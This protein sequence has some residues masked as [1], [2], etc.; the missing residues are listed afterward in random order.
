MFE[1]GK[2]P[3]PSVGPSREC[4]LGI[5]RGGRAASSALRRAKDGTD[6][7]RGHTHITRRPRRPVLPRLAS[8][9]L[10][11][12]PGEERVCRTLRSPR[13]LSCG[14]RAI[15]TKKMLERLSFK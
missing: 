4:Q 6:A 9:C 3:Q 10:L 8:D 14:I 2:P 5:R 13:F 7:L 1:A 12:S 11:Y 15:T